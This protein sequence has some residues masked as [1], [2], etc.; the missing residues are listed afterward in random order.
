MVA[1]SLTG[2]LYDGLVYG[3]APPAAIPATGTSP[4]QQQTVAAGVIEA[5]GASVSPWRGQTPLPSLVLILI[6]IIRSIGLLSESGVAG[7]VMSLFS[8]ITR[9]WSHRRRRP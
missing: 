4:S 9:C 1:R 2:R 3:L 6:L 8:A 7:Q 5:L